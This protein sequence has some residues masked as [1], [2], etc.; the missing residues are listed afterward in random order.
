MDIDFKTNKI[1]KQFNSEKE[2]L[3]AFGKN[4]T[5]RLKQRIFELKSADTLD[6]V[7]QYKPTRLHELSGKEN[8]QFSVDVSGNYRLLF[9][10]QK[11]VPIV[12]GIIDRTAVKAITII[13]IKD[14]H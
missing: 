10:P 4:I 13:A 14:T 8:G 12:A 3:K 2:M 9:I 1:K 6:D 7:S 11:P 5:A